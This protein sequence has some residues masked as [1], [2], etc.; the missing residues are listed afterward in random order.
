MSS[1]P[2]QIGSNI[3]RSKRPWW[4]TALL[5]VLVVG[6]VVAKPH[7]E[8]RFGRALP[9]I[10]G[11]SVETREERPG[12][13]VDFHESAAERN[14]TGTS[15]A[16]A[17]SGRAADDSTDARL[18]ELR[19]VSPRV[20]ESAAGLRYRPGSEEGHRV[21]HVLTHAEDDPQRPG[22]H[23][24]FDGDR[25]VI[26]AVIDEAY[27]KAQRGGRDVKTDREDG[28]TIHTVN[29]QKRVGYVGGESGRRRDHP[30]ARHVRLV[31]EGADIIT[32]FP[33]RP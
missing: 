25:A 11:T 3:P 18:G 33:V 5:V 31:L 32:A 28:R 2:R 22:S 13:D 4:V 16:A 6:Y 26:L 9:E 19:E 14:G 30:E 20:F 29:M 23:G 1:P 7:L 10:G 27:L 8:K 24:V 17:P 15:V 21:D 12:D